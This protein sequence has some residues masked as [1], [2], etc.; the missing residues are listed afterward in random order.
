[1]PKRSMSHRSMVDARYDN[2]SIGISSELSSRPSCSRRSSSIN[3][4]CMTSVA[5]VVLTQRWTVSN[6]DSLLKLSQPGNCLRSTV[7]RDEAI[8]DACWQLCLY[9]GGKREENA[10][11]VSLFLK[12]SATSPTKEVVLKAEYR[13]YFLD[14]KEESKFSNV[15]IGEFHAKPPKGGH[16]WGLRNIPIQ[17]VQ[18]SI[19]A[20]RSLVI[21]C[22]IELM[23]DVSKV[24]CK[25][26]PLLP[27][28]KMPTT[29]IPTTF[30]E[31]EL[32]MLESGDG[33]DMQIT[34]GIDSQHME[35]FKV[36]SYKLKAHSDVFRT[37][38]QY[39]TMIESTE[40]MIRITDFQPMA[41]KAMLQ[42]LYAGVIKVELDVDEAVD[43]MQIADKY[44]VFA[45][46]KTCEQYL[47][48][49]LVVNNV[50]DCITHAD[51]FQSEVLL[52]ACTDFI[53]HNRAKVMNLA[54]WKPFLRS[55]PSLGN[56]VME[57]MVNMG[58][59]NVTMMRYLE[60]D[61][62]RVLIAVEMGMKNHEV[63]PLP[64]I[65]AIAG[66]HRGA[67]SRTLSDLCKHSLCAFERSKKFDG[68]RLTIRG[69][70][71]LALR[72]L[73]SREVVG[74][75]GNQIGI[76]K[77]SDVYVGGDPE[78]NDLC[79]KFHRLGRTSFRKVK[80]KRDYH[81]K[82]K[83]A[84]WLYLS[85]LAA[86]KEF[87]FLK[88]LQ[89]RGFPVPNAVDVCRHVVVMQLVI[90]KTLCH[91]N[92][93]QDSA[94]LYDRLMALIMKLARHGVIHGDFNEF[95]LILL[96]DERVV[97]IDFPQM[98][99]IDHPN[100]QFY[101]DRD[102][103]CVKTF[104]K[105]RFNYESEDWPKFDEIERKGN[106]DVLLA[107]SGFTK[108][109]ALDLNKAYDEGDF[110]AHNEVEKQGESGNE[111]E[112]E[113]NEGEEGE[114]GEEEDDNS[115]S[116]DSMD[117][118]EEEDEDVEEKEEEKKVAKHQKIVLTQSTRFNDWLAD[119]T[120]QLEDIDINSL[121]KE[122]GYNEAELPEK[123]IHPETVIQKQNESEE[124]DEE[125]EEHYAVEEQPPKIV[126]KKKKVTVGAASIATSC[127]TFTSEEIKKKL[128]LDKKRNKEKIRLKV[129]GKQSATNRN[130]KDNKDVIAEYAG[131]I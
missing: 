15:N 10:N 71:Y 69:Y 113:E 63:V 65:S 61:H 25:K 118:I 49:R 70:D 27:T 20:D 92:E 37:M 53:V 51:S 12:M 79:L 130:R 93:V 19:R 48:D 11:N 128:A 41:V 103:E 30:V 76:G 13:F 95:N 100:A 98:V 104:F 47:L 31:S 59:M 29:S 45:L 55:N 120:T 108:K 3:N 84:S 114:K 72:A 83:S 44:Q 80:E 122:D 52:D 117:P 126:K 89:D 106:M 54:A 36:H 129:K 26:V 102:V 66:I 68:Y 9:P 46:K 28:V 16:S 82:R 33:S 107:A 73:C 1:M 74:S 40:Q 81:N 8:P 111:D 56:E 64:L 127:A 78:L 131:W 109:M 24:P 58:R 42:F 17:K 85:R 14:D 21:S 123:L 121:K 18:N 86:A 39:E 32:R 96:E 105:R 91:V 5:P 22:T 2:S 94:A 115:D 60:G 4:E 23:P 57:R 119:A 101:F 97:M 67:V 116:D 125:E 43:V 99:S 34:A 124:D 90:G 38:L 6:F 50:L 35:T 77:E 87:A 110:L 7:F 88:A 112:E 75:V 62:F